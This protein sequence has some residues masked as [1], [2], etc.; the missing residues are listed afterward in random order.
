MTREERKIISKNARIY[1]I[2]AYSMIPIIIADLTFIKNNW[3]FG[4][5]LI[6]ASIIML[7]FYLCYAFAIKELSE[8]MSD[9]K[10]QRIDR[11]LEKIKSLIMD[12]KYEEV[13]PFLAFVIGKKNSHIMVVFKWLLIKISLNKKQIV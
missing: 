8:Y 1:A 3:V 7:T 2:I 11:Y 5:M 9:L 4:I 12:E 13:I 10:K 6:I